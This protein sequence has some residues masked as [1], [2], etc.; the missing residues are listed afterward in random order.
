MNTRTT[1]KFVRGRILITAAL[2]VAVL[3]YAFFVFLPTQ[4]SIRELHAELQQ[5]QTEILQ[6]ET[7]LDTTVQT[8][9]DLSQTREFTSHWCDKAPRAKKLT[10]IFAQVTLQAR[11]SGVKT[12]RF[13]PQPPRRYETIEKLPLEMEVQGPFERV[14][15]FVR[16]LET[17]EAPI[18][19][20]EMSLEPKSEASEDLQCELKMAVFAARTDI[21]D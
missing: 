17:L 19:V 4:N 9:R 10:G 7:L 21:S 2:G 3:A 1:R 12:V 20:E 8:E 5:K 18:W 14:F 16:R 13:D 11:K 15:D 6:A